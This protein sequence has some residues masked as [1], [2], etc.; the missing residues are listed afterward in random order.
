MIESRLTLSGQVTGFMTGDRNLELNWR[1][2]DGVGQFARLDLNKDAD[3]TLTLEGGATLVIFVPGALTDLEKGVSAAQKA[4]SEF[5][6]KGTSPEAIAAEKA[7]LE[8]NLKTARDALDKGAT[9]S[10]G[11]D[12]DKLSALSGH[13]AT[14]LSVE[15]DHAA[16]PLHFNADQ[17]LS[18]CEVIVL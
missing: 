12:K 18:G 3:Q 13:S 11:W 2:Q 8:A 10:I 9:V 15:R 7:P 1:I 6:P 16:K 14:I 17:T 5:K 4:L